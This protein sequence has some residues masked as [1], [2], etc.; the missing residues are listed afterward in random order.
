[1]P[2]TAGLKDRV[3]MQ[4]AQ[5]YH[6]DRVATI[7]G[8]TIVEAGDEAGTTPE[9]L[10]AALGPE[11]ACVLY[12]AH[13]E[14]A[15]GTLPLREVLKIAHG[16]DVPVLV[17]ATGQIYPLQRFTSFTRLGADLVCFGAKYIG[18]VN[19]SGILCG[20]RELIEAASMQSFIGY[21]TASDGK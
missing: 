11:V 12:P 13:A 15:P 3:V 9:Q 18:A 7:V 5:R 19:S 17:D 16:K 21:E 6:H 14:A 20:N 8:T 1:L 10:A 2:H 4:R